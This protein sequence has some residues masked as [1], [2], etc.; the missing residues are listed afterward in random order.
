MQT[1][2][3]KS[4]NFWLEKIILAGVLLLLPNSG[5]LVTFAEPTFIYMLNVF[6]HVGLGLLVLIPCGF[7]GRR[8]LARD[9]RRGKEMAMFTGH[10]G[11][12]LCAAGILAALYLLLAGNRR[13]TAWV[14]YAHAVFCF[15]G[16]VFMT[17][18]IRKVGHQISIKN[19]YDTAGRWLL[20]FIVIGVCIPVLVHAY[21][22]LFT[23]YD[24]R[25][26]NPRYAPAAMAEEASGGEHGPFFP[27]SAAT[28]SHDTI[29][30]SFMINAEACGA[31][32]CHAEIY[33][34]WRSSPHRFSGF[35]NMWYRAALAQTETE[36][37]NSA[38]KWCAGCHTPAALLNGVSDLPVAM[39]AQKPEAHAGITC[40]TCH[41][42]V[43]VRGTMGQA[44][45]VVAKPAMLDFMTSEN[46][47]AQRAFSWFVHLD[48]K[49]HRETFL[50]PFHREENGAFCSSCHKGHTDRPISGGDW[51][52]VMND[53]DSWQASSFGFGA[54]DYQRAPARKD[55]A[56][57]HMPQVA[58]QDVS[59][60]GTASDHRFLGGNT[61]LPGLQNDETRLREIT[62]YLRAGKLAV[63]IFALSLSP[64]SRPRPLLMPPD[65]TG[66]EKAA[67][68]TVMKNVMDDWSM[69]RVQN[70]PAIDAVIAPLPAA[71][72]LL[73][74]QSFRLEVV[75]RSRDIGHFFPG[76]AAD[77]AQAWLEVKIVDERDQTVFW[78][79][80]ARGEEKEK[81]DSSAHFYGVHMVDRLGTRVYHPQSWK[82]RGAKHTN[83]L[84]PN[85]AEVVRYRVN[86][87]ADCGKQLRITARLNYRK[88]MP[89]ALAWQFDPALNVR[90]SAFVARRKEKYP[91]I[92]EMARAE[93]EIR[94][95]QPAQREERSVDERALA[96][97]WQDY[98]IGLLRQHD[99]IAAEQAFAASSALDSTNVEVW[100]N[101]GVAKLRTGQTAAAKYFF[102]H[103][104]KLDHEDARAHYYFAIAMK[105]EGDY[106]QA[107]A[108]VK[109]ASSLVRRD[110]EF[111]LELGR[112]H[113]LL[114]DYLNSKRA[115]KRVIHIDPEDPVIYQE[116]IRTYRAEGGKEPS[117]ARAELLLQRF[118][119][120][121]PGGARENR[122]HAAPDTAAFYHE[123]RSA[124]PGLW[125]TEAA[126]NSH[127]GMPIK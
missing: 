29:S 65:S 33:Q 36:S 57:C 98:G 111:H 32:G 13:E 110:R 101:R 31:A 71:L 55:C 107:L 15:L 121:K 73:G 54:R 28:T 113:F 23:H 84:P 127:L 19:R 64:T 39:Q 79:G 63:D 109:K 43:D 25:I 114:G 27:A 9:V 26:H 5:Y 119:E 97:R 112:L 81:V 75:V 86:L 62:D 78:S 37:G 45:Y 122:M 38:T 126:S 123:Y 24:E 17:A 44:G 99:V 116:L 52:Q 12:W 100:V 102:A 68:A 51:V 124:D 34:Q 67:A 30:T 2:D 6:L 7:Y 11:F 70:A 90:D 76:G 56:G 105:R 10:L 40:T 18:A 74:Q 89:Q 66:E 14:L 35:S 21:R 96:A 117:L 42:M 48:S 16:L 69:P 4:K 60:R 125:P 22:F 87:P 47:W 94:L 85:S 61:W 92:I 46:P 95:D 8:L 120:D 83:L 93:A 77:M 82:T 3:K 59:A 58:A 41:A 88:F 104:L 103:A 50:Q 72:P 108:H 115:Y 80:A 91:P 118:S 1:R 20:V 106:R 53:Y 49:P